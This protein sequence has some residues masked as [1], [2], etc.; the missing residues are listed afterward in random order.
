MSNVK[1]LFACGI[2]AWLALVH[3]PLFGQDRNIRGTV[4]DQSQEPLPSVSVKVKGTQRGTSTNEKGEFTLETRVGETLVF[5]SVGYK[6][7]EVTVANTEVVNMQLETDA[8]ALDELVIIG[9]GQVRKSDLTGSLA[10]VKST[11]IN[12]FPTTNIIQAL[13]G[14][15][16]GVQ[17][18]QNTG[19][20]GASA[21]VR[22]RG[23][24]SIQGNNEPLYV[25]DG[26]PMSGTNPTVLNNSDIE[27]VEILKDASA[28]AIYGSRGA[29]GVILIT[30]RRGKA[31]VT[32]VDLEAS[33]GVQTLRKKLDLMNAREFASFY[34][35]QAANDGLDPRFSQE[36]INNMGEGFDWQDLVFQSAPMQNY[37]L[38]IG[39]GNDN[40][41]FSL[42][43]S[44]FLQ[45]GVIKGSTYDRYS[46]RSNIQH[47]ISEKF[48]VDGGATLTRIETD[49][50]NSG[51]GNR[52]GSMISA[53]ISAYPTITPYHEDGS[54]R[55]LSIVYPWGSNVLINPLNHINETFDRVNSNR[56]LANVALTYRPIPELAIRI[57]GGI[58]N[59]DDRA[60]N[61]TSINF[62]NSRGSANVTATQNMSKL[63]ENTIT[64]TKTFADKHNLS[65]V[66][67]FTYQDFYTTDLTG[68][69][70][71]FLSNITETADLGS[72]E[73][74]G[75]PGSSYVY[76]NLLSFL[77]RVNYSFNSKYLATI[78]FRSDGS[79]RYSEGNKWGYFPSGA[80]SWRLSEEN[81]MKDI[82]FISDLKLRVGYGTTGSQAISPY[83]T[84]NQLIGGKTIFDDALFNQ[85]AP[86]TRLPGNLKWETT[87]QTDIGIDAGLWDDRIR[88][89]A[90]YYIK[91]TRDLLNT[92]ALP[93]SLGFT[94]TIQNVGSVQNRG[95]EF[96]IDANIFRGGA[97]EWD[98]SGNF[99]INRNKVLR[100]HGG[101]DILGGDFSVSFISDYAN[102]LREGQPIGRFWGYLE[103]G[104]TEAGQIRFADLD[105][106]G[107]IT[108]LD[109]TYIGDPNPDFIYGLN[110]VMR[111]KGLELTIF[112][113]GTQGNDIFNISKINNTLDYNFG[114]NMPREVYNDHWTP[115]NPNA[116][117]PVISRVSNARVS[118]RMVEDGSYLRLRNIQL[119][120]SL[121]VDKWNVAWVKGF[122]LYASGQNLL[123]FTKY[124]WWDPEVNTR[125]GGNSTA[126]GFD[127]YSYPTAKTV[128]F[129]M[130]ANF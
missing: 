91:N 119:A 41:Q 124:S 3:F 24:N 110:S 19:A 48:S 10:Q 50:R 39:G 38:T 111:F 34:N 42:G 13:N 31:G 100:L 103:D 4:R 18:S 63:S 114:L 122:Q 16:S 27:S 125:G 84:L 87:A 97:F 93:A 120:Y 126:Q 53:A 75:I 51:G 67:G 6:T 20:P 59:N 81:F 61:Y 30:T 102:I 92:V 118:D 82:T 106:D 66:A 94:N 101:R 64:Y 105:G 28:T 2:C 33:Y 22:I 116:K 46:F 72:A 107:Q 35:M 73:I 37:N 58:E 11:E 1:I 89:V 83:A 70:M 9:Y 85:F 7:Q 74:P 23:T 62:Q 109:K 99:S 55:D 32:N 76:S 112:L 52:G 40:T 113:Q 128:T 108:Q 130:R 25:V 15:A 123:T 54:L 21:S 127:Y 60:D 79:S 43:G 36:E 86:G 5:S 121:P 49:R 29:N 65:A 95:F 69:G 17:V 78:S 77:G 47:K 90:D 26:F 14:R 45:D 117:Y 129:G 68:S 12:A 115:E 57:A 104:Y 44:V 88:I 80:L 96:S 8:H 98:L 71:G 56:I